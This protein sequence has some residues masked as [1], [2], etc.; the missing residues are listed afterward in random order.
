MSNKNNKPILDRWRA[1]A[2]LEANR[3]IWG[4]VNI[5][6]VLGV[7]LDK[8]RVMASSAEVPIYKPKG[9]RSYFA[10]RSELL[11]WLR[12]KP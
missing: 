8:A 9:S 10:F 11:A 2:L 7:S 3:P 6:R 4:L 1:D 5:A 12:T